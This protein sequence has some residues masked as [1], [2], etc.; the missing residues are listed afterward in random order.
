MTRDNFIPLFDNNIRN[1]KEWRARI[2][3]YGK[4][5]SIQ[6]KAKEATINLLTSLNGVSWRQ[7]EPDAEK[8]AESEDGFPRVLALLDKC[9]KYDSRVEAP[10]SMELFFFTMGRRPEQT[11]LT[12]VAEHK[13]RQ[14]EI[15]RHGIK[16]PDAI[17]GWLLLRRAGLTLEQRHLVMSQVGSDT[18]IAKVESALYF[19]FG[20]DFKT[21]SSTRWTGRNSSSSW[22][23]RNVGRAYTTEE[24]PYDDEELDYE[25]Y[26]L[27]E[28]NPELDY[29]PEEDETT[30]TGFYQE[31]PG[32]DEHAFLEEEWGEE[33]ETAY[34]TYLDA[35]KRFSDLKASRGF[36]P[37]YAVPPT[38]SPMASSS[39]APSIPFPPSSKGKGKGKSKSKGKNKSKSKSP[40]RNLTA[41]TQ[42]AGYHLTCLK[43][44]QAGHWAARCP[45]N[46]SSPKSSSTTSSPKRQKSE[47]AMMALPVNGY[48]DVTSQGKGVFGILD[49]GA[50]SVVMGH[51]TMLMVV[52]YMQ[53]HGVDIGSVEFRPAN[54]LF[55]FGG[56][57]TGHAAWSVHLP[58]I[59]DTKSG[60][61]QV[62]IVDG[63]T[64]F[65]VG[66][67]ILA[68]FGIKIDYQKDTLSYNDGPWHDAQ[69]GSKGE[70]M[71]SMFL[72]G[73]EWTPQLWHFDLM[74]DDTIEN[75]PDL[76][77]GTVDF[78][79]YLEQTGRSPGE[80]LLHVDDEDII[81]VSGQDMNYDEDP[82]AVYKPAGL[83]LMKSI[84]NQQQY[85]LAQQ[86][87]MIHQA[88]AVY[89]KGQLQSWE[90]YSGSG[91]LSKE[92]A[93]LGHAVLTFD[94]NNGWDFT[95]RAHQKA[96]LD[97]QEQMAPRFVWLAPPC[98]KWSPLQ[99]LRCREPW[100][101]EVLQAERDVEE[102][103]H[104][105][106]SKKVYCNQLKR[107]DH[108]ILESPKPSDSWKTRTFKSMDEQWYKGHLDQCAVG[109]RLPDHDGQWLPIK[110]P[111]TL[112]ASD[113][114]LAELIT[115]TCPGCPCHLPLEGS[116]PMIGNRASAAAVYQ[117]SMCQHLAQA[118]HHF[119]MEEIYV[120]E[121]VEPEKQKQ[122]YRG[123]MKR[124]IPK[125][126]SEATRTIARL[127][128]N[129]GHP[130]KAQLRRVLQ[131]QKCN[132]LLMQA[133]EDFDCPL[134][135]HRQPP[136]QVPKTGLYR[137]TFFNDRVQADTM[138]LKLKRDESSRPIP[139]LVI[140][141]CTTRLVAARLLAS[142]TT[143]DF[144]QALE[145]SW[146]RH[147]GTMNV[148]QVDEHRAWCSD[149]MRRWASEHNVEL[150]ISPGQAHER[151]SIL[152]RRHQVVRRAVE[153]F[154]LDTQD[155][156]GDGIIQALCYV[157]PQV[158]RMP[159][160]HGFSPLQWTVG[161]TPNLPGAMIDEQIAPAQL[162]PSEAFR[163]KMHFQELATHTIAKASNDDRLRR[164]LLRQ[165]R[166]RTQQ[167]VLGQRCHY[168]RD[169]PTGQAALGPKIV[170][171]GPAVVAMVD[172]EQKMYWLVHGTV[173]IRASFEHT[174]PII[175]NNQTDVKDSS[176]PMDRARQALQQIRGR[177]VTQ[178]LDL[179][180]SNKRKLEDA[181]SDEEK[182]EDDDM[183]NTEVAP[184]ES[185]C[186]EP[187]GL[188]RSLTTH[189]SDASDEADNNSE[190]TPTEP[191]EE[192]GPA[193]VPRIGVEEAQSSSLP[194]PLEHE[195][196]EGDPS[197][198]V[199]PEAE[200]LVKKE[201]DP[202][203]EIDES[204][205][206]KAGETFS[207][208]AKRFSQQ[209]TIS[210]GP[211]R[212]KAST[213]S[214]STPYGN[215][216]LS[217]DSALTTQE[218]GIDLLND[219]QLPD[220]WHCEDGFV[221]M[222]EV[223]DVWELRGN[224]LILN[225]FLPRVGTYTPTTEDCPIKL[226][227][228]T[229]DRDSYDGS[230]HHHDRWKK[231]GTTSTGVWTGQT[232]FKI[233]ACDRK[234]A[235]EQFYAVSQG[236]KTMAKKADNEVS[237]R[238]LSL[239]DRLSFTKAKQKELESFFTNNVWTFEDPKNAPSERILTARF[240][241][242]WKVQP[243]K[244]TKAKARLVLRGFQDPDALSGALNTNSPT[245]TR[246]S[247]GMILSICEM[248]HFRHFT[249]DIGTAFL[250]GKPHGPERVLWVRLPRDAQRLLGIKDG[251]EKVM[252]LHKSMYGLVDAP[253]SWYVEAVSR[254]LSIPGIKQH[255]LDA[256]M[257]M[258][259]DLDM[260]NQLNPE[261][262][263]AL[264]G[265]FGIHVDDLVGG[266]N[267]DSHRFLEVKEQLQK[268]FTFRMWLDS[269]ELGYCGC[270]I[271][272]KE[273][274]TL[275]HQSHYLHKMKPISLPEERKKQS[276]SLLTEKE[277]SML[278]GLLGGLQWPST[279]TAPFLQCSASQLSGEITRATVDTI[280]RANKVLRMAKTNADAGLRYHALNGDPRE[281]T[282]LG[283]T[284]AS[285]ASRKDLSWFTTP[286]CMEQLA[287]T[288][289]LIGGHGVCPGSP[290]L[291]YRPR[292]KRLQSALTPFFL[293]PPFG[294]FCGN[295]T[296]HLRMNRHLS[297]FVHHQWCW[298]QKPSTTC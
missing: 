155:Y 219:C 78:Q 141:D 127:H 118:I 256:C 182:E 87:H 171:R 72:D 83:K 178:Y 27:E 240:I 110:K 164:A 204:Y 259:F 263:G 148:L 208:K 249:S 283:Y 298:T 61:I 144:I 295:H 157:I 252:K 258:I 170:W 221:V 49:T 207:E 168:Y 92:L 38:S 166:G 71:M 51:Q 99:R 160:V 52:T 21:S 233:N 218:I 129:L 286:S 23:S 82:G 26:T 7:V 18:E 200:K 147:F 43:C 126:A 10:R 261:E 174:R 195:K 79:S 167:L 98:R 24:Y 152:E 232:R 88:L 278:R 224:H 130:P 185:L 81:D 45:M 3:L 2:L 269:G 205:K 154:L 91:N 255:P 42:S 106:F 193:K 215:K 292:A 55:Q 73:Q 210:F 15:E 136:P 158:N 293:S 297:W 105:R 108:A 285:F 264:V 250:R 277:T 227:Y 282:F 202:T 223:H 32:E 30:E 241:L 132:D 37:V 284:D 214:R 173:L 25:A 222:G 196:K 107:K 270:K 135:Q 274:Y 28:E 20:Q 245:L 74:T 149:Q 294:R 291:P 151:L 184:P 254:I 66:R 145:R 156:T 191:P 113:P 53:H 253:R 97:L 80:V 85:Q 6:N 212:A 123:I 206:E 172:A 8:L 134:C 142:E 100:Q 75:V 280:D 90:L 68:H 265:L 117:P 217:D 124:L 86:K 161:Y 131:E 165:Y 111:T 19:L 16:V 67:P 262:P 93:N 40:S 65:L 244:S 192:P 153:L 58:V 33:V 289:S 70:Y 46:T 190:Y 4:K 143:N 63:N 194:M 209:E 287:N 104:L 12:Y 238:H 102:N 115:A 138:W 236:Q 5:M 169:L 246:L 199:L 187:H 159:N 228:L 139:I 36:W 247:R 175:E 235:H 234:A 230:Q 268:L 22:K 181:Q 272:K 198:E 279:Q 248:L 257:F 112:A 229:K 237:E 114:K 273:N 133:L 94:I 34:A 13:E 146:V 281:V 103:T 137:G 101:H 296:W 251:E 162:T 213:E 150:M 122:Q 225:H 1:Y 260:P 77:D 11:L 54:K 239:A 14:R 48:T 31:Q 17:S 201:G 220:G 116:S 35:R 186:P 216:P 266:G 243:D 211:S 177:G 109:D 288:M 242:T 180:R 197:G 189:D 41:R 69:R 179:S 188:K 290:V 89:E 140:S 119:L 163:Q 62:F 76:H 56:D 271:E 60:R 39:T 9:F 47:A 95:Q 50:S 231:K 276:T 128:R 183:P 275:L 64:P 57:H 59:I 84:Q 176:G 44:G 267:M 125:N 96:F 29:F 226:E 121:D 120:G 203:G